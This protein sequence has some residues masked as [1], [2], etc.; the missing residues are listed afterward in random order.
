MKQDMKFWSLFAAIW[1]G[2]VLA[3]GNIV[4][5]IEFLSTLSAL[6]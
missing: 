5:K 3:A 4:A 1:L 2:L 6:Q